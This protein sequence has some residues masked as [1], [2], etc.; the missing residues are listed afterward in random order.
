MGYSYNYNKQCYYTDGHERDNV[1]RDRDD[2]FLNSY[3][4]LE[5]KAYRWVQLSEADSLQLH[6]EHD[7]FKKDCCYTFNRDG[8]NFMEYH[9][10]THPALVNYISEENRKYG[11]NLSVRKNIMDKPMMIIGQDESTYHQLLFS[12]KY[13][14]GSSGMSFITPK[15]N[16]DVVMCSG[17]QSHKFGLGLRNLLS[18]DVISI[19]NNNRRGKNYLSELDA[20][21]VNNS[22]YK[23]LLT[24]NP[25]MRYFDAGINKDGYWS[26][27]HLKLQ[28][29]DLINRL[30]VIFPQSDYYVMLDQSSG[31]CKVREDGLLV[32]RMNVSYGGKISCMRETTVTGVGEF[33][34]T[35]TT[36]QCQKLSSLNKT[37]VHS[38]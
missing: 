13:W 2:W 30:T 23:N 22:I 26:S 7:N 11:G 8:K 32:N 25:A 35:L 5:T 1:V 24:D 27:S 14:K 3:F 33:A 31:H 4:E 38:G 6:E 36:G 28:L 29:E 34:A 19:V 9:V 15:S 21:I 37:M 20:Q 17:F 18:D 10:D 12:N 16:G